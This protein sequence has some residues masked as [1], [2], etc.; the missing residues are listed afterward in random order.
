MTAPAANA[1]LARLAAPLIN[2]ATKAARLSQGISEAL[3]NT[4]FGLI[5]AIIAVV[6]YGFFQ[7]R[8][9]RAIVDMQESSMT[10]MNLVCSNREKMKD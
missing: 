5:V 10:L 1:T 8:I 6:A 9:S 2:A 7:I 3:N 4:A